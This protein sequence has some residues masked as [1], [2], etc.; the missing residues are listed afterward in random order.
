MGCGAACPVFAGRRYR[1][2]ELPDLAGLSV[3][4][5]RPIRDHIAARVRAQSLPVCRP[6]LLE[7]GQAGR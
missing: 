5:V 4:Q 1:A 3:E 7:P 2:R 6:M